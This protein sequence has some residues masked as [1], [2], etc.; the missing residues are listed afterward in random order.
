MT[1]DC[2]TVIAP[3]LIPYQESPR[4][5]SRIFDRQSSS[6]EL[7]PSSVHYRNRGSPDGQGQ[8]LLRLRRLRARFLLIST[9]FDRPF[10][11]TRGFSF[12][13]A[14]VLV[15]TSLRKCLSTHHHDDARSTG[16]AQAR[17]HA[18]CFQAHPC[19]GPC[20]NLASKLS[21]GSFTTSTGLVC[22]G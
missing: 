19:A 14:A 9:A 15:N 6:S 2:C 17:V 11:R 1:G 12:P 20:R 13:P 7:S 3:D 22:S 18:Y 4:A 16:S 5:T 21:V 8:R 10:A